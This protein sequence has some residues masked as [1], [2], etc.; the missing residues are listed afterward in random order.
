[1]ERV[2]AKV[3][4]VVYARNY[5]RFLRDSKVFVGQGLGFALVS[6]GWKWMSGRLLGARSDA[7]GPVQ[8][9]W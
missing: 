1:M 9:I 7:I 3:K 2:P 4:S 5:S 6:G 8:D